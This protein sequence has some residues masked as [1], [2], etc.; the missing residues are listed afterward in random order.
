[1]AAAIAMLAT[2]RLQIK[3]QGL[4]VFQGL[5]PWNAIQSW[6]F[7][8]NK[9]ILEPP[10]LMHMYFHGFYDGLP[11]FPEVRAEA[12]ELLTKLCPKTLPT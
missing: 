9:L 1:M 12:E 11:V 10:H 6:S 7:R 3:E 2:S 8:G 4:W 5:L